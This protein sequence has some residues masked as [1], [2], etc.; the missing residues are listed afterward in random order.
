[1]IQSN[2]LSKAVSIKNGS[3]PKHHFKPNSTKGLEI[4]LEASRHTR[5]IIQGKVS[6]LEL[7]TLSKFTFGHVSQEY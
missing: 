1:M 5:K 3:H 2:I 6:V 4:R 7:F